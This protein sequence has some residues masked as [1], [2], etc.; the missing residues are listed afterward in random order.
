M[1]WDRLDSMVF[2]DHVAYC[3]SVADAGKT[4]IRI[5]ESSKP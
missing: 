1:L 5:R 4:I 3:V 2:L